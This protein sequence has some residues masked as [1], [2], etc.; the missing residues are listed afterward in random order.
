LALEAP[1]RTLS[2]MNFTILHHYHSSYPPAEADQVFEHMHTI[3]VEWGHRSFLEIK[4]IFK[5]KPSEQT[6]I[7]LELCPASTKI[8]RSTVYALLI[9]ICYREQL[10]P[11]FVCFLGPRK[12]LIQKK[13]QI[14]AQVQDDASRMKAQ[15]SKVEQQS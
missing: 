1:W 14:C 12:I 9:L 4:E 15:L 10:N 13:E 3:I 2:A 11:T 5:R 7:R 8:K 6:V